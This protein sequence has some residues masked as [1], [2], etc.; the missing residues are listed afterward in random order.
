M[1]GMVVYSVF[2]GLPLVIV[3]HMGTIIKSRLPKPMSIA[4]FAH[5]RFG[6]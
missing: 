3:A 1:I 2:A 4:S 5:W 6:I